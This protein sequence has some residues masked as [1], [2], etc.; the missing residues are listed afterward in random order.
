MKINP[1][2]NIIHTGIAPFI[3]DANM[4]VVS[5][6]R[7]QGATAYISTVRDR[8]YNALIP[9]ACICHLRQSQFLKSG[10]HRR[11][12]HQHSSRCCLCSLAA[13]LGTHSTTQLLAT[14]GV[15]SREHH[16]GQSCTIPT[17]NVD[18]IQPPGRLLNKTAPQNSFPPH[19]P[20]LSQ[21]R[22]TSLP[23]IL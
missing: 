20:R 14:S 8:I 4:D 2:G 7:I 15:D 17:P 1:M 21:C 6:R 22:S 9:A 10:C 12:H 5:S 18:L 19:Q 16:T 3:D 23:R 11:R 13:T